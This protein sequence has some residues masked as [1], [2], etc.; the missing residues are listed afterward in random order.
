[1]WEKGKFFK[2]YFKKKLFF[3]KTILIYF[4]LTNSSFADLKLELIKKL[5][6]VDT[7]SFSFEQHV[8]GKVET[9]NCKIQYPK[10][11]RCD[12]NDTYE[13][14]L[15][16]NGK[17]LAIIQRRYKKIFYYNFKLTP[18]NFI[19]D[20]KYLLEFIKK[21]DYKNINKSLIEYE[22]QIDNKKKIKILFDKNSLNLR[23]WKT[24]DIYGNQVEFLV[25]HL[26]LNLPFFSLL[27]VHHLIN[28]K[29]LKTEE[30][31]LKK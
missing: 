13:K 12:Y 8:S 28:L 5:E 20:K 10:L 31:N 18:L 24:V 15:I 1:M 9:G 2:L 11:M 6:K 21:K 23:G 27:D 30:I 14:R 22:I 7:L 19:L 26:K 3:A 16:S 29:I 17:T 4:F 25:S